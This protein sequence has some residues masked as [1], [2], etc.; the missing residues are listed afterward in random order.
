[1]NAHKMGRRWGLRGT[2]LVAL[3]A[4]LLAVL[5]VA[6]CSPAGDTATGG[7][8]GQAAGLDLT[9]SSYARTGTGTATSQSLGLA[10][11]QSTP[12]LVTGQLLVQNLGT[13]SSDTYNWALTVDENAFRIATAVTLNLDAGTYNFYFLMHASGHDYAGMAL[14]WMVMPAKAGSNTIPFVLNPIISDQP[15]EISEIQSLML[16][17]FKYDFNTVKQYNDPAFSIKVNDGAENVFNINPQGDQPYVYVLLPPGTYHFQIK[18]YDGANVMLVGDQDLVLP[19]ESGTQFNLQ[20]LLAEVTYVYTPGATPDQDT[21]SLT[22]LI[23]SAIVD[24]AGGLDNVIAHAAIVGPATALV[25]SQLTL[26]PSTAA[27][28]SYRGSMDVPGLTAGDVTFSIEFRRSNGVLYGYCADHGVIPEPSGGAQVTGSFPCVPHLL[29][30]E[31]TTAEPVAPMSVSVHDPNGQVP[32]VVVSYGLTDTQQ[33]PIGITS[34]GGLP[35][36][37]VGQSQSFL[38]AGVYKIVGQEQLEDSNGQPIGRS[39]STSVALTGGQ[40]ALVSLDLGAPTTPTDT[41]APTGDDTPPGDDTENSGAGDQTM[42]ILTAQLKNTPRRYL[43]GSVQLSG[44]TQIR[45][46][47]LE[48]IKVTAGSADHFLLVLSFGQRDL[49]CWYLGGQSTSEMSGWFSDFVQNTFSNPVCTRGKAA[50]DTFWVRGPVRARVLVG[51]RSQSLTEVEVDIPVVAVAAAAPGH[52]NDTQSWW[53]GQGIWGWWG[54]WHDGDDWHGD[55][56]PHG[57]G[58]K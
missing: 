54:W 7:T 53:R 43:D 19:S 47:G 21:G 40:T 31:V 15:V 55:D 4:G 32:G 58:G 52:E 24:E 36:E 45:V 41:P 33:Q 44:W 37:Q 5:A 9:L 13:G 1:M 10:G 28:D 26:A 30:S 56:E 49:R 2:L 50:G 29:A 12:T 14:N 27:A 23:P 38:P 35:F 57:Q 11:T 46:P 51:D 20:P 6:G 8:G 17:S 39:A 42:I 18:F 34:G 3:L 25:E 48:N 16:F 22:F